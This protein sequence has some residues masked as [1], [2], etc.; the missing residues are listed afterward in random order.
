MYVVKKQ[1][2]G[3]D[4][5]NGKMQNKFYYLILFIIFRHIERET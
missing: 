3:L 4:C 5:N 1:G 2:A